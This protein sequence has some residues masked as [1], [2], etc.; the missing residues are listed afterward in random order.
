M[1]LEK[2]T[3]SKSAPKISVPKRG[4]FPSP[5]SESEKAPVYVPE[6]AQDDVVSPPPKKAG[7]IKPLALSKRLK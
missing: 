2:P 4:A 3:P 6:K 5:P 1:T 7:K